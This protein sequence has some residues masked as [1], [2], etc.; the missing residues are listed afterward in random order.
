MATDDDK[1]I[2]QIQQLLSQNRGQIHD[3]V[4]GI[5]IFT[6]LTWVVYMALQA[7]KFRYQKPETTRAS[8]PDVEKNKRKFG[9]T[10]F[11]PFIV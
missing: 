10:H 7:L 4:L 2:T 5:T 8:T 3:V 9:G 11:I 1:M 6:S